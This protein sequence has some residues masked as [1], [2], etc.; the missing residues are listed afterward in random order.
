M[1]SDDKILP[2]VILQSAVALRQLA[3]VER[4][5]E[6]YFVYAIYNKDRGKVYVGQTQDLEERL[7]LH[8]SKEFK[9][10]YTARL[11]GSWILIYKEELPTREAAL[12]REKQLKSYRGR[13]FVK[14][15]I[16]R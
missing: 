10:S 7:R 13:E 12:K 2:T 9:H 16:P 4:P 3:E 5:T 8:N 15:H 6:M 11:G 1:A 14:T